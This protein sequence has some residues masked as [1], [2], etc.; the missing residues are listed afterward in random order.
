MLRVVAAT[1][2]VR[3][4]VLHHGLHAEGAGEQIC[5]DQV[6][7]LLR[8]CHARVVADEPVLALSVLV[9]RVRR[10]SHLGDAEARR[11]AV[12]GLGRLDARAV[13]REEE[14]EAFGPGIPPVD[15]GVEGHAV[16][17]AG[18]AGPEH[19]LEAAAVA[20]LGA[21]ADVSLRA[22]LADC[23]GDL[24]RE[25]RELAYPCLVAVVTAGLLRITVET[26]EVE[27]PGLVPDFVE[28]GPPPLVRHEV[29]DPV[30]EGVLVKRPPAGPDAVGGGPHAVHVIR[31]RLAVE[32][33]RPAV[34][35]GVHLDA[36]TVHFVQ[37]LP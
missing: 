8:V 28:V 7:R 24:A 35:E 11:S 19:S 34:D 9:E 10:P 32:A 12:G 22:D 5:A 15:V 37:R 36:E 6:V 13:I 26:S 27:V 3:E 4:V 18:D 30:A 2:V 21:D 16:I 23:V 29:A 14:P 31:E 1:A 20:V 17:L 33:V 25:C